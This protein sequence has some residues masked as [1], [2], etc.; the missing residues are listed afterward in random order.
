MKLPLFDCGEIHVV[1]RR[2]T[3]PAPSCGSDA[4]WSVS[5]NHRSLHA[6]YL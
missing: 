5:S 6:D 1:L 3:T 4:R 2:D